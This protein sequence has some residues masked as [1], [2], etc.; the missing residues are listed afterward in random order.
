MYLPT[1]RRSPMINIRRLSSTLTII[2]NR[3]LGKRSITFQVKIS[4][5]RS[6]AFWKQC[7]GCHRL[8]RMWERRFQVYFSRS[9]LLAGPPITKSYKR[10]LIRTTSSI[11]RAISCHTPM[12]TTFCKKQPGIVNNVLLPSYQAAQW[13]VFLLPLVPL[14]NLRTGSKTKKPAT[15][16]KSACC[17]LTVAV[18]G[19]LE[20]PRGG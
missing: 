6:S 4:L 7:N 13:A 10:K 19:G 1:V 14:T 8:P 16:L 12:P 9:P 15:N 20:P 17:R 5:A 2:N 18:E 11:R 3:L